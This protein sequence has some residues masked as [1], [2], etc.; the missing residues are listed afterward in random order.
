MKISI[1]FK[2]IALILL[3]AVILSVGSILLSNTL[4]KNMI[5]DNYTTRA[6]E[7]AATVAAVIDPEPVSRLN[8]EVMDIYND[9]KVSGQ[10]GQ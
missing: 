2:I 3:V 6:N 7:L 1:R 5:D 4:I 8:K 10:S 9:T